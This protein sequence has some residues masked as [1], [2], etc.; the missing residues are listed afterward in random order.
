MKIEKFSW[1]RSNWGNFPRNPKLFS[2]TGGSETGGK[3]MIASE[4]MDAP[5]HDYKLP[6][7][8]RN[9]DHEDTYI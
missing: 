9:L 6:P 2:E 8:M 7:Q 3:C 5:G 1:K 4:G